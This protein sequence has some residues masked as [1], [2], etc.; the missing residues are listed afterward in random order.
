MGDRTWTNIN[1]SFQLNFA[2][3]AW[4]CTL[5][6]DQLGSVLGT[7][8]VAPFYIANRY[9]KQQPIEINAIARRFSFSIAGGI[10]LALGMM[11]GKYSGWENKER[12]LQDR[13]YRIHYNEGQN[14]VDLLSGGSFL[15][16]FAAAFLIQ[17]RII[18]AL[19]MTA[20][21]VTAAIIYHNLTKSKP[22]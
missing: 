6:G 12:C 21:A 20:P 22:E 19:G 15:G 11:M 16:A 18:F 1:D 3:L 5:K 14:R 8:L 9:R 17:R 13:A 2:R 7:M 10:V 4:H